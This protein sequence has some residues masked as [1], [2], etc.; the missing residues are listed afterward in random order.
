M[1]NGNFPSFPLSTCNNLHKLD[2]EGGIIGPGHKHTTNYLGGG[3]W[4]NVDDGDMYG[5]SIA[6]QCWMM[7]PS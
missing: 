1:L 5:A 2:L 7:W 6:I 4:S 3:V